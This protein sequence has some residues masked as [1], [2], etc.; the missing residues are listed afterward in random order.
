M[1]AT[2]APANASTI[3]GSISAG[4]GEADGGLLPVLL[5]VVDEGQV[6]VGLR[7]V[8]LLRHDLG[9]ARGHRGQLLA[10][11][12]GFRAGSLVRREQL[13]GGARK[14]LCLAGHCS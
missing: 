2:P 14:L 5:S 7:V 13:V 4:S 6:V 10:G 11:P 3:S 8:R 12:L 9:E 1:K